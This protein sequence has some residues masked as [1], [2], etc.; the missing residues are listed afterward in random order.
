VPNAIRYLEMKDT[1]SPSKPGS[2][3]AS[4]P[5]SAAVRRRARWPRVLHIWS[6]LALRDRGVAVISGHRTKFHVRVRRATNLRSIPG[7]E[8]KVVAGVL[9]LAEKPRQVSSLLGG[10][11]LVGKRLAN[12]MV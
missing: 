6:H 1:R 11:T 8:H 5:V 12:T 3:L 4:I 9:T 7:H 10:R 2:F